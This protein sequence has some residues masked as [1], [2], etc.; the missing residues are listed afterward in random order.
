MNNYLG[1]SSRI[2]AINNYQIKSKETLK[3]LL[4]KQIKKKINTNTTNN[5]NNINRPSIEILKKNYNEINN[6]L[7]KNNNYIGNNIETN[8]IP[9]NYPQPSINLKSNNNTYNYTPIQSLINM[10]EKVAIPDL[11]SLHKPPNNLI[12]NDIQKETK[13]QHNDINKSN[14][15][16]ASI[17]NTGPKY[18]P[19]ISKK[20]T[21]GNLIYNKLIESFNNIKKNHITEYEIDHLIKKYS[22]ISDNG[23]IDKSEIGLFIKELKNTIKDNSNKEQDLIIQENSLFEKDTKDIDYFISIDSSDRDKNLWKNPAYYRINFGPDNNLFNSNSNNS[24]KPTKG[25]INRT[26]NNIKS[27]ELIEVIIPKSLDEDATD[28]FVYPYLILEIEE[29]GS[30]YEGTNDITNRAFA[31]LNFDKI[32]GNYRYFKPESDNKIVKFFNPRIALNKITIKLTKP[33]G[34]LINFGNLIKLDINEY[35]QPKKE[36]NIDDNNL[37]ENNNLDDI[38]KKKYITEDDGAIF[39]SFIFKITCIQRSLDT[40][41][42][43]K[44]DG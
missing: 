1:E 31:R 30:M 22:I 23:I 16:S 41:Y 33:D 3:E 28:L 12:V 9:V 32:I 35:N 6:S 42:L 5:N 21:F 25:Y 26:F 38:T 34:S 10:Q 4:K 37:D 8:P 2:N 43:D 13:I 19:E 14:Y 18:I 7:L 27:I 36:V 11:K 20:R 29:F 39:N 40:M 44:R 17:N 15:N 24:Y